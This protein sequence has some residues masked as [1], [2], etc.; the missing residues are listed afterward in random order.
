MNIFKY[1]TK[2]KIRFQFTGS[3]SV[4][5]LW[6]LSVENLDQIYMRLD[7]ELNESEGKSLLNFNKGNELL[8]IKI[9]IVKEIVETKI[10]EVE[11]KMEKLKH[12]HKKQ[13]MLE[14]LEHKQNEKLY[15][16]S[17]EELKKEIE[18]Y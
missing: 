7:K 4:E 17:E 2:N 1:A 16:M 6:Q 11:E 14:I 5:D 8:K 15:S 10:A 13:N 18:K 3:L 9:E 12:S